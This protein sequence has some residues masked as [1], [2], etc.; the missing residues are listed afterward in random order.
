MTKNQKI[1]ASEAT[2]NEA[3][4]TTPA[5]TPIV[6][7]PT[8]SP[9]AQHIGET[10]T[11]GRIVI[12]TAAGISAA[13][14]AIA[15][16]EECGAVPVA[17]AGYGVVRVGDFAESN[18]EAA[19]PDAGE[20]GYV[21]STAGIRGI[22]TPE[23][24]SNGIIGLAVYPAHTVE[25]LMQ[26]AEG[27][28]WLNRIAQKEI[29]LVAFRRL[30]LTE[31][32]SIEDMNAAAAAMPTA[33]SDFTVARTATSGG[34]FE[35]FDS[36]WV[37]FRKMLGTNEANADLAKMLT[38]KASVLKAI[39]SKAYAE[40]A[41]PALEE[42]GLIVKVAQFFAATLTNLAASGDV[43]VHGD[44]T[45]IDRWIDGRE[46]LDLTETVTESALDSVNLDFGAFGAASEEPAH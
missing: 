36:N 12:P 9:V 27:A 35:V 22:E 40:Q 31:E 37:D 38:P 1:D 46:N 34:A 18:A 16:K 5:A 20:A 29:G 33:A 42:R 26:A 45:A 32:D 39:R 28:D 41:F 10:A 2:V 25:S 21:L 3:A 14:A 44:V 30:R 15:A 43:E 7:Y 23:G 13:I 17:I 6:A 11:G 19:L 4:P 24:K 8:A